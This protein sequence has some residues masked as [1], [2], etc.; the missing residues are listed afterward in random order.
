MSNYIHC[1]R[2]SITPHFNPEMIQETNLCDF[3]W[4]EYSFC[5]SEYCM[6]EWY[7]T[8]TQH[9]QQNGHKKSKK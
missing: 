9:Y 3:C 7:K 2:N 4:N 5:W 8:Q 1:S 6:N